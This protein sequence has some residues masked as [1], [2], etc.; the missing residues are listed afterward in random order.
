MFTGLVEEVGKIKRAKRKGRSVLFVI[1][2]PKVGSSLGVSESVSVNGVCLTVIKRQKS[3]FEVQAVEETLD[4]TTLDGLRVGDAVNLERPL[5][6]VD[7]VG[8]HFVLG[9]ID[10]VAEVKRIQRRESSNVVLFKLPKRFSHYL[11]PAGSI[12]IDGVSLT[13]ALLNGSS[14][15]VSIIPH[16]LKK[17]TFQSL[18]AGDWVNVEFDVLGKYVES[19]LKV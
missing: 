10:C 13:I 5:R 18:R 16:T 19:F 4:K 9:H 3:T 15:A 14:F 11:I 8:G 12:A 6:A 17:T 2:A 7:R 1:A